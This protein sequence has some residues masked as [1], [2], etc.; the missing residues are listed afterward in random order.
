MLHNPLKSVMAWD[1]LGQ[2]SLQDKTFYGG[3]FTIYYTIARGIIPNG[4]LFI[5]RIICKMTET[6]QTCTQRRK[7]CPCQGAT[8]RHAAAPGEPTANSNTFRGL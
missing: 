5:D 8:R 6:S 7:H 4:S 2:A 3:F 1:Y